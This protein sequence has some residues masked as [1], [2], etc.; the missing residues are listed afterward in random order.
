MHVGGWKQTSIFWVQDGG[1]A[2]WQQTPTRVDHA[3]LKTNVMRDGVTPSRW[4][5]PLASAKSRTFTRIITTRASRSSST[6]PGKPG[7]WPWAL[8]DC[9]RHHSSGKKSF[10]SQVLV[11]RSVRDPPAPGNQAL[12]WAGRLLWPS[13]PRPSGGAPLM[14][15]YRP[16]SAPPAQ[17]PRRGARSNVRCCIRGGTWRRAPRWWRWPCRTWSAWSSALSAFDPTGSCTASTASSEPPEPGPQRQ[18]EN[19]SE[20]SDVAPVAVPQRFGVRP[21]L[22][23]PGSNLFTYVLTLT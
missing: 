1:T 19:I 18:P 16:F 5:H 14:R 17:S 23:L 20:A 22:N 9:S 3:C 2:A 10:C 7:P 13:A 12:R 21:T 6:V 4:R 11:C 15:T 8:A